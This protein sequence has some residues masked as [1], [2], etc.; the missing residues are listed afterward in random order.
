MNDCSSPLKNLS[1]KPDSL[2]PI[3]PN[4]PRPPAPKSFAKPTPIFPI[5]SPIPTGKSLKYPIDSVMPF[6]NLLNP[7]PSALI[8]F[9]P[10]SSAVNLLTSIYLRITKKMN[11]I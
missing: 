2:S 7:E 9:N 8:K 11:F 3:F 5:S 10:F 6:A 4:T 1:N